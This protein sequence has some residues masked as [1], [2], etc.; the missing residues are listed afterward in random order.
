MLTDSSTYEAQMRPA[1]DALIARHIGDLVAPAVVQGSLFDDHRRATDSWVSLPPMSVAMRARR[2]PGRDRFARYAQEITVR[3]RSMYG[4]ETEVD[5]LHMV[6][7]FAYAI[8]SECGDRTIAH[9]VL[10]RAAALH[11][12][13]TRE[14]AWLNEID[15]GDGTSFAVIPWAE[16]PTFQGWDLR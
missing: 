16:V 9:F 8:E 4:G 14:R 3:T 12:Y 11:D 6:A 2:H 5:K 1:I 13:I 15:N 10:G 7:L